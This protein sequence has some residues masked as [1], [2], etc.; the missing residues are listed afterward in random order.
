MSDLVDGGI[1]PESLW[2][3][4][5]S[6]L[7]PLILKKNPA[8]IYIMSR[9]LKAFGPIMDRYDGAAQ[10]F[11]LLDTSLSA[12]RLHNTMEVLRL[13]ALSAGNLYDSEMMF[14][15]TELIK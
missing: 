13:A 5:I 2:L 7:S 15:D 1:L 9:I 10:W 14:W 3:F 4:L 6:R 12:E 11:T 8:R